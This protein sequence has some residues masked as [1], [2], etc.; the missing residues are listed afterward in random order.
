M[1]VV[2]ECVFVGHA[3]C[4]LPP[5]ASVYNPRRK[6]MIQVLV[7]PSRESIYVSPLPLQDAHLH[8]DQYARHYMLYGSYSQSSQFSQSSQ[9]SQPSLPSPVIV[10]KTA[11]RVL[12]QAFREGGAQK[13]ISELG[14]LPE[15]AGTRQGRCAN[16]ERSWSLMT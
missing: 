12:L 11:R 3:L 2:A 9:S 7:T 14:A 1:T 16:A 5:F 6:E 4:S 10:D 8:G 15:Q 13:Y